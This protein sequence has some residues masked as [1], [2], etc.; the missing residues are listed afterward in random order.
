MSRIFVGAGTMSYANRCKFYLKVK[1][2]TKKVV[3]FA[4]GPYIFKS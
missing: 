3:F 4:A 1:V 2:H